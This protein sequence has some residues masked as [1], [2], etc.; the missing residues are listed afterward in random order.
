MRKI[1][2]GLKMIMAGTLVCLP[3]YIAT[4]LKGNTAK[5]LPRKVDAV[6]RAS[7]E[8]NI[9]EV[10]PE[11]PEKEEISVRTHL[12]PDFTPGRKRNI[13]AIVLH[14]TEGS[15]T[16]AENWLTTKDNVSASAHYLIMENGEIVMLVKPEDTAWHCRGY[17][18]RSIGIEFAG[19]Y[20]KPLAEIQLQSGEKL[21]EYLM[22][23]YNIK[24]T[25]IRAHS[26]LDPSRRKDPGKQNIEAILARI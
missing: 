24:K 10:K 13:D 5:Q 1:I 9:Q 12:S 8:Y 18:S 7:D 2:D 22:Q 20:D 19:H 4:A 21:I 26:E 6:T 3:V 15:G 14:T 16:G 11:T 17:N 23:T 25:N